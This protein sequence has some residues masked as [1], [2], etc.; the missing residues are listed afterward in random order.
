MVSARY[1]AIN[2][3]YLRINLGLRFEDQLEPDLS[4]IMEEF[5][6]QAAK[7]RVAWGEE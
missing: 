1:L 7:W 6:A 4:Q 3:P 2:A 5:D